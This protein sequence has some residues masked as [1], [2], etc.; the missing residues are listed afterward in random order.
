MTKISDRNSSREKTLLIHAFRRSL[1]HNKEGILE[2]RS[3]HHVCQ[4]A[5][6]KNSCCWRLSLLPYFI[7][8][9]SQSLPSLLPHSLLF[10]FSLVMLHFVA[11]LFLHLAARPLSCS[12]CCHRY[13]HNKVAA[14]AAAAE[15]TCYQYIATSALCL[16]ALLIMRIQSRQAK[17]KQR[18]RR[19]SF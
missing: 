17:T 14:A 4:E 2:H 13:H 10:L 11:L 6:G 19:M 18:Q 8:V 5:W 15:F 3:S 1:H 12:Y 16:A 9:W 7:F